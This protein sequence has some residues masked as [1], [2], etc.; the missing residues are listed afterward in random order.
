MR[1]LV[2]AGFGNGVRKTRGRRVQGANALVGSDGFGP[3]S[4]QFVVAGLAKAVEQLRQPSGSGFG[5]RQPGII[6]PD[7]LG[8]VEL[9]VRLFRSAGVDC[10]YGFGQGLVKLGVAGVEQRSQG[11]RRLLVAVDCLIESVGDEGFV[12]GL[13]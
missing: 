11:L 12:P 8:L 1:P 9:G 6:R 5:L 13:G 7:L 2:A 10:G 3:A 4:G